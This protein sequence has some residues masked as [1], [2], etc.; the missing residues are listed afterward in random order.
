MADPEE[1]LGPGL[2]EAAAEA[3]RQW[4]EIRARMMR[5]MLRP[6]PMPAHWME[7]P[8]RPQPRI[9]PGIT[10]IRDN[11]TWTGADFGRWEQRLPTPQPAPAMTGGLMITLLPEKDEITETELAAV[12]GWIKDQAA[13][14]KKNWPGYTLTLRVNGKGRI[15]QAGVWECPE[16]GNNLFVGNGNGVP[17]PIWAPSALMSIARYYRLDTDAEL[18]KLIHEL[19]ASVIAKEI[20]P[21]M[22]D[23]AAGYNGRPVTEIAVNKKERIFV[24]RYPEADGVP[25]PFR[26]LTGEIQEIND[27]DWV[28]LKL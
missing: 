19:L 1:P 13:G 2:V 21:V 11:M 5:D 6:M 4:D 20:I 17:T 16:G 25:G 27:K 28:T 8:P 10:F 3:Q 14:K 24:G 18:V 9:D 12:R 23:L 15:V 22:T 26:H 7:P